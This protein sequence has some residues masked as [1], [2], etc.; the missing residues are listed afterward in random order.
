MAKI[1]TFGN[2]KGG[3]GKSALTTLIANHIVSMYGKSV[4]VLD[5]DDNQHSIEAKRDYEKI[6]IKN[7]SEDNYFKILSINSSDSKKNIEDFFND[8]DFI[9]IDLP[10]NLKQPGV[11][12]SYRLVDYLFIPTSLSTEDVDSTIN[13]YKIYMNEVYPIRQQAQLPIYVFGLLSKVHVNSKEYKFF[14]EQEETH[15][16]FKFLENVFPYSQI[17]QRKLNTTENFKY[18]SKQNNLGKLVVELYE[19]IK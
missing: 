2:L 8:F 4:L 6:K 1:I 19:K 15:Y 3:V 18:I 11:L 13:F 5:A 14:K 9:F 17:I 16:P 12:D 10:G 7:Y